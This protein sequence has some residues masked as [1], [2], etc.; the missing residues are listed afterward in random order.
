MLVLE[1]AGRLPAHTRLFQTTKAEEA[2][3]GADLEVHIRIDRGIRLMLLIQAKKIEQQRGRYTNLNPTVGKTTRRQI[4]VL[5]D[6]ARQIQARP[7]YLLYNY[8]TG[9]DRRY[10]HCGREL[11]EQQ[12]GCALVPSASIRG[13]LVPRRGIRTFRWIHQFPDA[14]P[15]RCMFKL[16]PRALDRHSPCTTDPAAAIDK[17]RSELP[18]ARDGDWP[19]SFWE[20]PT[21]SRLSEQDLIE[22]HG[23]HDVRLSEGPSGRPLDPSDDA[24]ASL[25]TRRAPDRPERPRVIPRRVLLIDQG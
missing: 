19:R 16:C 12:L 2:I 17:L 23:G 24:E 13:V 21:G 5:E 11:E 4:D 9:A 15:W 3:C 1:C 18:D 6:Y 14:M 10:W 25:V 8:I 7:L 22:L 20:R